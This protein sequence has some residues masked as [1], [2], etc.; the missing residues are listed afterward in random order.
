[1]ITAQHDGIVYT[2]YSPIYDATVGTVTAYTYTRTAYGTC[3][4]YDHQTNTTSTLI[5]GP[6]TYCIYDV[7]MGARYTVTTQ[8]DNG[9][10]HSLTFVVIADGEE[11]N[12]L[13]YQ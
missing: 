8:A 9:S 5:G 11:Y 7:D 3:K 6:D 13:D 12:P 4:V 1:M 2:T 10:M